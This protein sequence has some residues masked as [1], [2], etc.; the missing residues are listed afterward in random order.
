MEKALATSDTVGSS[1]V[2][3]VA[4]GDVKHEFDRLRFNITP[5]RRGASGMGDSASSSSI[6]FSFAFGL[7]RPVSGG[8]STP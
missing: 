4:E 3:K 2:I 7:C 1:K 6:V 8:I 5:Y